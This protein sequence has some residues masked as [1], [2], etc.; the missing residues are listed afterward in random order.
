MGLVIEI[1]AMSK[2]SD[3]Q[4][5]QIVEACEKLNPLINSAGL[6]DKLVSG[7]YTETRGLSNQAIYD[8]FITGS[9]FDGKANPKDYV[10]RIDI[11]G[12]F[13]FKG[14]IGYTYLNS[15]RQWVN[16]RLLGKMDA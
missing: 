1:A 8:L 6:R 11:Q 4:R 16:T 12:Y 13:T 5:R 2:L 15:I 7:F 9:D 14:V 10:I 3:K